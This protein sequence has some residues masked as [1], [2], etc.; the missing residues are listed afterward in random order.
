M[1]KQRVI[2]A[3]VLLLV[4]LGVLSAPQPWV[5]ASF[6]ALVVIVATWEWARLSDF[7]GVHAIIATLPVLLVCVLM[8]LS[9]RYAEKISFWMF[10]SMVV[11]SLCQLLL[12]TYMLHTGIS[13]WKKIPSELRLSMGWLTL[14][15]AWLA[16]IHIHAQFGVVYLLSILALVWVADIAAYFF[17]RAFGKRKLAVNISPG[18]SW[19]GA[20]GGVLGGQVLAFAV[21]FGAAQYPNF[22]TDIQQQYGGVAL[23]L[24]V[25]GLTAASVAGDLLESLMKRSMGM[26]DS[27]NLLPGHGGVLDRLDALLPVLPMAFSI[28]MLASMQ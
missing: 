26:K 1:L 13:I 25:A 20:L 9:Q 18:K 27:S 12:A 15:M 2:T 22:Y 21:A 3:V 23:A 14:I 10:A 7:G 8:L 6:M 17:G 24:I 11:W 19:E 4:F 5:F 16:A 28:A